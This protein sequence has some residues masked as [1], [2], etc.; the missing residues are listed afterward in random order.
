MNNTNYGPYV[1]VLLVV[2][3]VVAIAFPSVGITGGSTLLG[4]GLGILGLN[5][6]VSTLGARLGAKK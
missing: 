3:G 5:S 6:S 4:L 1:G 2:I